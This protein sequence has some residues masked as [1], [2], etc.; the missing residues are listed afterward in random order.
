MIAP[1]DV[2]AMLDAYGRVP[3]TWGR[4]HD[5]DEIGEARAAVVELI[6]ASRAF[7]ND[8]RHRHRPMM[9]RL[10]ATLARVQGE[11]K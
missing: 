8:D 11:S 6:E 4:N 5:R 7:A 10:H 2:L 9:V 1:V 3:C